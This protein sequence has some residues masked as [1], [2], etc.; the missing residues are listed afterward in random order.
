MHATNHAEQRVTVTDGCGCDGA[1]AN[2]TDIGEAY[3]FGLGMGEEGGTGLVQDS[4]GNDTYDSTS[5]EIIRA[6]AHDAR[7]V[8][9]PGDTGAVA[10]AIADRHLCGCA[11]S[12]VE[13]FGYYAGTGVLIDQAGDDT[14]STTATSEATAVATSASGGS[15]SEQ[16]AAGIPWSWGQGSGEWG[17]LGGAP[18]YGMLQDLGGKDRYASTNTSTATTGPGG[19]ATTATPRQLVQGGA[20]VGAALFVDRDGGAS[21]TF[22]QVPA[23]P[24]CQGIR[25]QGVWV[26]CGQGIGLGINQ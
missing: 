21:D 18:G 26:D 11:V 7:T 4:S 23:E 15:T 25:G 6:E 22:T 20:E 14:Y 19:E 24:A 9:H 16:A 8:S 2:A 3:V 5:S 17:G 12:W 1:A 10:S 13:G